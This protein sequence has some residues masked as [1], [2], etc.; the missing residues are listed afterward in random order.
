[1]NERKAPVETGSQPAEALAQKS[2][3]KELQ[4]LQ[5]NLWHGHVKRAREGIE[6]LP[7]ELKLTAGESENRDKLWKPLREFDG[8][9]QN[10]R[11]LLPNYGERYRNGERIS[12]A[13]VEST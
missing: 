8:Y 1:V 13:L 10:H 4:S 6:E 3:E 7:W 2:I 9:I 5:G 12:T 11:E